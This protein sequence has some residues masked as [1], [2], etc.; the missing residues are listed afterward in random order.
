MAAFFTTN[1][2]GSARFIH[3]LNLV[4]NEITS[5]RHPYLFPLSSELR[6][7]RGSRQRPPIHDAF[8]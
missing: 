8:A 5:E 1:F 4:T 7:A 2:S 6:N 3:G